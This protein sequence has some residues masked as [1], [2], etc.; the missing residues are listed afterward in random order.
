MPAYEESR[1]HKKQH[2]SLGIALTRLTDWYRRGEKRCSWLVLRSYQY[3]LY[4]PGW[5]GTSI[6]GPSCDR[7][8]PHGVCF[9]ALRPCGRVAHNLVSAVRLGKAAIE[10]CPGVMCAG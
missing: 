9:F 10:T 1:S 6:I 5:A 4:L 3:E 2:H 7:N 8:G